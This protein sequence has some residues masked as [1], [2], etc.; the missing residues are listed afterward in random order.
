MFQTFSPWVRSFQFN[1]PFTPFRQMLREAE[2]LEKRFLDIMRSRREQGAKGDDALSAIVRLSKGD[3]TGLPLE[4]LVGHALTLFLVAY[5]T[6]GNTLTWTLFLL[7]QH[8]HVRQDLLDELAP[9]HGQ[10]PPV[11]QLNQLPL[12]DAVLKSR[13]ASC[14]RCP[15]S[16]RQVSRDAS[17]G[18]YELPAGARIIF[19]HYITHHLPEIYDEPERFLPERWQTISPSP[20]EYL[21]FGAGLRTCLGASLAPFIIKIALS[22]ILPAWKLTVVPHATIDRKLGIS[23]G[24]RNGLPMLL[25]AQ[26][27]QLTASPIQG[28]IHEMVDLSH[29]TPKSQRLFALRDRQGA[30]KI[31]TMKLAKGRYLPL[32]LPRRMVSDMLFAGQQLTLIPGERTMQL[33]E[34]VSA[35]QAAWPKPSWL[36]LFIKAYANVAARRPELR[37]VF[38]TWP[39]PRLFEY[40]ETVV[41][42]SVEREWQGERCS[43]L[44]AFPRQNKSHCWKSTTPCGSSKSGLSNRS[45]PF[46]GRC[47]R[48]PP[49]IFTP[50]VLAPDDER[51]AAA[52]G[53][54]SG[55][56]R[57]QCHRRHG[58]NGPDADYPLDLDLFLWRRGRRRLPG[59]SRDVRPPRLR[60]PRHVQHTK[61]SRARAPRPNPG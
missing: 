60:R 19:S 25:A 46:A 34:V 43:S 15:D 24:P 50:L 21:P 26:D 1:L 7:A 39:W 4:E 17:L 28:N 45:P 18:E 56:P 27:R 55:H 31:T 49:D 58:R 54:V 61:R 47:A 40:D 30:S 9:F 6:T 41:A 23:L 16:R 11:G 13:C 53:P 14:R 8:P 32:S 20:A 44:P 51:S 3:G 12:L 38:L 57:R 52:A 22:M 35:R 33:A 42:I 59:R 48:Q 29:S 2:A 10:A 37:R 5:E 36:S